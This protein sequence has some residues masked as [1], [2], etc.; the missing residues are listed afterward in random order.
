M[1]SLVTR[2]SRALN[3]ILSFFIQQ[4]IGLFL[5]A[6][7]TIYAQRS[8]KGSMVMAGKKSCAIRSRQEDNCYFLYLRKHV[9]PSESPFP[10]ERYFKCFPR[11][12]N[13]RINYC[14]LLE[15]EIWS[16]FLGHRLIFY[17]LFIINYQ[18]PTYLKLA[19]IFTLY[20]NYQKENI[21][22][23][24]ALVPFSTAPSIP[25]FFSVFDDLRLLSSR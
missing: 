11:Y 7:E 8:I 23:V 6:T 5:K 20:A 25:F 16:R 21:F 12:Y 19:Q 14:T 4:S 24:E 1:L 15:A 10:F 22:D 13:Y 9:F 18:E 3:K 2:T 17:W